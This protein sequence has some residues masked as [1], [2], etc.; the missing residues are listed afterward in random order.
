MSNVTFG[1]PAAGFDDDGAYTCHATSASGTT[2]SRTARVIVLH[3]Y[4][5]WSA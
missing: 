2:I 4:A 5:M 1:K 3:N